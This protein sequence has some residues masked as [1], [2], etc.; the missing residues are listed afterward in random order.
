MSARLLPKTPME[1]QGLVDRSRLLD[2]QGRSRRRQAEFAE[3]WG[4]TDYP[5][6]GGGCLLTEKS[7]SGRLRDLFAHQP[8]STV[9]DVELLKLGRQFRLSPRAKLT[10]GRDQ[11]DNRAI[12][13]LARNEDL[14]LH[15]ADFNGPLGLV[16]GHPD[17]EDLAKAAALVATYGKGRN[18]AEVRV[19]VRQGKK[20]NRLIAVRP[21]KNGDFCH[22]TP[23]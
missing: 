5:P 21:G 13:A 16:S 14:L 2:I 15:L 11:S 23:L 19:L 1:E 7:F 18:E 12:E 6:S 20:E 9:I 4:L 3:A 22:T 8:G 17:A 10:L